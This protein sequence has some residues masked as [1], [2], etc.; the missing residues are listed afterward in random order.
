M[1]VAGAQFTNCTIEE[2]IERVRNVLKTMQEE[3]DL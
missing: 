3:G 2:G 1:S